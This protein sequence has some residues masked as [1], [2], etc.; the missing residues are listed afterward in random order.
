MKNILETLKIENLDFSFPSYIVGGAVRDLFINPAARPKDIDLCVIAPFDAIKPEVERLGGKVFVEKPEYLTVRCKLPELGDVDIAVARKDGEYSDGR[1]PDETFVAN[2]IVEDLSR[3]DFTANA[4]AVDLRSG[5]VVDPFAGI[6]A[7]AL[8]RLK[9]VGDARKRF[10]ED[11]LRILRAIRFAICKGFNLDRG[12]IDCLHD[13]EI[14]NGLDRI[15]TE[16]IREELYKCFKKNTY[17]TLR[18]LN[19]FP[20]L[21]QKVF[22][23]DKKLWLEPSMKG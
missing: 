22:G 15:T 21:S 16:R 2:N 8:R 5:E 17:E 7:I 19:V 20:L 3:R 14:V 18:Y 13:P 23:G 1:R 12:I 10:G 4:I 11:Y 6:D 9:T